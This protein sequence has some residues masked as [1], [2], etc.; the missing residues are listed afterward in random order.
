MA[1][2]LALVVSCSEQGDIAATGG[3]GATFMPGVGGS[4]GSD[5]TAASGGQG[6]G[7]ASGPGGSPTDG[8]GGQ[9]DSDE[10]PELLSEAGLYEPDMMTLTDGVRPYR[11]QFELWTDGAEKKRYVHL[12]EGATIDTSE[13]DYWE[14]PAGTRLYKEFSRDG[15]RI[16][17]RLLQRQDNGAWW[18]MAY[19]WREDQTEADA[20][21]EGVVDAS[22]TAHDIPSTEDCKTCHLRMPD[23]VLG[24]SAI[25]LA[26]PDE[27]E[28]PSEWSLSRLESA[29]R[30]SESPPALTLPGNA[31]TRAAL[32]Y[33]HAN[34]GHCHNPRSSVSSRVALNL[35]LRSDQLGTL[36]D[37]TIYKSTVGQDVNLLPDGPEGYPVLVVAGDAQSSALFARLNSRG[38]EYSMPP[39]GTED[40]DESGRD[41]VR[42]WIDSL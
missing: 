20:V 19:Q 38:E 25:Q 4:A 40:I 3:M 18:M 6:S 21:P 2:A 12:P 31:A 16:E 24:F 35:W 41:L 32:G 36:A 7:G 30:L 29:G 22:T 37:T 14:F 13:L 39:L 42:A 23:K 5:D 27:P 9:P 26:H 17:T 10:I 34:C 15:I 8:M 28:D 1:F 11:P 33:L